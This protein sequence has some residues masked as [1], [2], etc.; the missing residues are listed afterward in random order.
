M[1]AGDLGDF[2]PQGTAAAAVGL[3]AS[4]DLPLSKSLVRR[5]LE[6]GWWLLE[7]S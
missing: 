3:G 1:W 4:R 5:V 6:V 2:D 7:N